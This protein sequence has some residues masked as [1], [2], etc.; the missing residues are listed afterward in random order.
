MTTSLPS[1]TSRACSLTQR[2]TPQVPDWLHYPEIVI[3]DLLAFPIYYGCGGLIYYWAGFDA[4]AY[5]FCLGTWLSWNCVQLV[6]S[7]AH[8]V[9]EVKYVPKNAP[10]CNARNI[11]YLSFVMLG[12]NWHSNRKRA[13]SKRNGGS[14]P[15]PGPGLVPRA[16]CARPSPAAWQPTTTCDSVRPTLPG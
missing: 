15:S 4:F 9:G 8:M 5:V 6:N 13:A 11:W 12:A 2:A 10:Q 14:P 7:M 3:V 1:R 16:A